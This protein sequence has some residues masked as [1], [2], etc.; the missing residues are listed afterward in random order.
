[1]LFFVQIVRGFWPVCAILL[2]C[3]AESIRA[4]EEFNFDWNKG[5][6]F[7]AT[8]SP[9]CELIADAYATIGRRA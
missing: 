4:V 9:C 3:L 5:A 7:F 8:P 1:V 2:Y 6:L